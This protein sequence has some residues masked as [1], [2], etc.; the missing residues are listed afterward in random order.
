MTNNLNTQL[1]NEIKT[2]LQKLLLNDNI[3]VVYLYGS[4]ATGNATSQSD[5]DIGVVMSDNNKTNMLLEESRIN[6]ELN[7]KSKFTIQISILNTK[8]PLF[9]FQAIA[10]RQVLFSKDENLRVAF[11]VRTFNEYFD[12]KKYLDENYQIAINLSKTNDR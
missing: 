7:Y 5:I 6:E 12:V 4:Y 3:L 10:P 9:R 11:E 1:K 2:I 8:S